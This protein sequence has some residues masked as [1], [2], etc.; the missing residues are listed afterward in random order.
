MIRMQPFS[1]SRY[2]AHPEAELARHKRL[3]RIRL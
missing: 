1:V 3:F 2:D